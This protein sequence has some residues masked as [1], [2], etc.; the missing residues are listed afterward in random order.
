MT[1]T[2]FA[3]LIM[4]SEDEKVI[5]AEYMVNEDIEDEDVTDVDI[6]D[7]HIANEDFMDEMVT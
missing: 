7:V 3:L 6:T 1:Y 5:G 4:Q 2:E